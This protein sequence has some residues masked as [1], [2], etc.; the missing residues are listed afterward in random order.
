[1]NLSMVNKNEVVGL[2]A[3]IVFVRGARQ[4]SAQ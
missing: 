4:A 2:L 1:M 3:L